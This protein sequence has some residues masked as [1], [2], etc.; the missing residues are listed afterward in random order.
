MTCEDK[1]RSERGCE[2]DGGIKSMY[3]V[4]CSEGYR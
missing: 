2:Y 4:M 1:C 3:L